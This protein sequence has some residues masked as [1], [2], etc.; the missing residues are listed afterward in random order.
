[1]TRAEMTVRTVPLDDPHARR[2][3]EWLRDDEL[4]DRLGTIYPP[5]ERQHAEWLEKL[6]ADR[7][8]LALAI[9]SDERH[10]GIIGLSGIDLIYRNAEVWL[11]IGDPAAR[12]KGVASEAF[13]Q[14]AR[15]GFETLGLHRL[16]AQVFQFNQPALRFFD[17]VGM[18]REGTLREAVFK[19]GSFHDKI[20]FG[21]LASEF[22]K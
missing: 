2:M 19:R 10:V 4:R 6:A 18:L 22:S 1:M 12:G 13:R 16:Y 9:E 14:I 8:R 3:L 17:R 5:S 7:T 11:Y 20:V 21:M 15:F